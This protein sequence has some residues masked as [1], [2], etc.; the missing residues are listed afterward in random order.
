MGRDMP[1]YR[2]RRGF[3]LTVKA[4]ADRAAVNSL[5]GMGARAVGSASQ[6]GPREH[7]WFQREACALADRVAGEAHRHRDHWPGLETDRFR[8]AN[9]DR[10]KDLAA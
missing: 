9:H 7:A 2:V 5:L 10:K 4:H 3:P 8:E 1:C 6:L